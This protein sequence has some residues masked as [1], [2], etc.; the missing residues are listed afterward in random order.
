M[1][2]RLLLRQQIFGPAHTVL[3]PSLR[4]VAAQPMDEN[5]TTFDQQVWPVNWLRNG[6]HSAMMGEVPSKRVSH[7]LGWEIEGGLDDL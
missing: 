4:M 6:T 7:P 2:Q 5:N 1:R 3:G